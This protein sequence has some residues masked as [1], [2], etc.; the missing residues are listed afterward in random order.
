MRRVAYGFWRRVLVCALAYA[1]LL[2]GLIVAWDTAQAAAGTAGDAAFSEFALCSHSGGT[3]STLPGTLPH[4]P[5]GDNNCIFCI[6]GAVYVHC[7]PPSAAQLIGSIV[8][9]KVTPLAARR[10]LAVLGNH[11]AWPR[12]PPAAA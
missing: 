9:E 12:G 2:Q 8:A 10:L 3:G 11:S 5:A 1:L 7:A 6:G 4:G